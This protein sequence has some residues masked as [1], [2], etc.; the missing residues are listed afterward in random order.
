MHQSCPLGSRS[1]TK[2][3]AGD[4]VSWPILGK[5]GMAVMLPRPPEALHPPLSPRPAIVKDCCRHTPMPLITAAPKSMHEA[6]MPV[7]Q[8]AKGQPTGEETACEKIVNQRIACTQRGT[9]R[10]LGLGHVLRYSGV[11]CYCNSCYLCLCAGRRWHC[12]VHGSCMP[13]SHPVLAV[14][15]VRHK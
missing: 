9:K 15:C 10:I 3:D 6:S 7:E 1:E 13:K 4:L 11:L 14:A 5:P 2:V 8:S 12:A